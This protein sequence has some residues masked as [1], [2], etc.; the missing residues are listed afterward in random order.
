MIDAM[1]KQDKAYEVVRQ[2]I[3]E[4]NEKKAKGIPVT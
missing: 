4:E 3:K 2:R 1:Q